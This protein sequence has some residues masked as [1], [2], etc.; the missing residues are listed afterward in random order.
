MGT[1]N[2]APLGTLVNGA[3]PVFLGCTRP[4]GSLNVNSA[5]RIFPGAGGPD[6]EAVANGGGTVTMDVARGGGATPLADKHSRDTAG[7]G[8][9]SCNGL[10]ADGAP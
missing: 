5:L 2:K 10:F 1:L 3:P 4:G 9:I 7:V 6:N 8:G